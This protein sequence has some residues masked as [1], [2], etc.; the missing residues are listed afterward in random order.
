[1]VEDTVAPLQ[2]WIHDLCEITHFEG[3][4]CDPLSEH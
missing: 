2:I 1:M 3:S 4:R